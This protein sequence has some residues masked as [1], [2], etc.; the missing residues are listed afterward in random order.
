[1]QS[2]QWGKL[3]MKDFRNMTESELKNILLFTEAVASAQLAK[4]VNFGDMKSD[5]VSLQEAEREA[6]AFA[7]RR[8]ARLSARSDYGTSDEEQAEIDSI[9]E[10]I[11][12][13]Y[14]RTRKIVKG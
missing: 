2:N 1:M 11:R 10:G 4:N 14:R 12:D 9:R 3:K 6:V 13:Y 8:R 5:E 7:E